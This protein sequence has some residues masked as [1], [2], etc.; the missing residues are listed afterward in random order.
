MAV[1][2]LRNEYLSWAEFMKHFKF[3]KSH[4]I[5]VEGPRT[6]ECRN[7]MVANIE[8]QAVWVKLT[9][10]RN[11]K[12]ICYNARMDGADP[13][14]Q[15]T[16]MRAYTTMCQNL[17]PWHMPN[18]RDYKPFGYHK[19]KTGKTAWAIEPTKQ[20]MYFNK[21]LNNSR[22]ED[23]YGYDRNSAFTWAMMQPIPNTD[24]E[25]DLLRKTKSG[26]IGFNLDGSVCFEKGHFCNFIFEAQESPFINF[27]KKWYLKKRDAKTEA[28]K[29][30]A[31]ETLNF[32]IGYMHRTNPFIRNCI[33]ARSNN[34][35]LSLI[36]ENTLYCNT[37]S[38][39]SRRRRRDLEL[40]LGK[41]LGQW[42]IEHRGD[43]AY[44]D[45]TYQWNDTIPTYR[46]IPKKWFENFEKMNKRPWDLLTDPIPTSKYNGYVWNPIKKDFDKVE[47]V[48]EEAESNEESQ[49]L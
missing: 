47:A 13:K 1:R 22:Y 46:G 35:I 32:C 10:R 27:A 29:E 11:N 18:L 2:V 33:V 34:Y 43:F 40:D 26:E 48:Y 12:T 25:P 49:E 30:K 9:Y 5:I 37:D 23:C 41:E 14:Q 39:V 28:D 44:K 17:L 24:K 20:L 31:K 21:E 42:K 36:D 45:F 15:I 8:V 6:N 3:C 38:I 16:G 7:Y 4:R 19:T